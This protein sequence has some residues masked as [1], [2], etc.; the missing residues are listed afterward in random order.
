MP[1]AYRDDVLRWMR[2]ICKI[3]RLELETRE[4]SHSYSRQ[5][6]RC[7]YAELA[8]LT[9]HGDIW[10]LMDEFTKRFVIEEAGRKEALQIIQA[11][12]TCS[13]EC[14]TDCEEDCLSDCGT[15]CDE[16]SEA[17][18][19]SGIHRMRMTIREL[20]GSVSRMQAVYKKQTKR[21]LRR[22]A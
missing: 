12:L 8:L 21:R 6:T 13:S 20:L 4:L 9:D 3:I 17:S 2:A 14:D 11:Q 10:K 18:E 5:I 1:S 16:S 7:L 22:I 19:K 15:D